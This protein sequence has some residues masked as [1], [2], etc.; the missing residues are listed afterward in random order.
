MTNA[1]RDSQALCPAHPE[2]C[3]YQLPHTPISRP[4]EY[5]HTPTLP[6]LPTGNPTQKPAPQLHRISGLEMGGREAALAPSVQK[7]PK[8][9]PQPAPDLWGPTLRG[10]QDL[11][12]WAG[13]GLRALGWPGSQSGIPGDTRFLP[14]RE[15]QTGGGPDTE[16]AGP[17]TVLPRPAPERTHA[18]R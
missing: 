11:L 2:L 7:D 4:T 9:C 3:L 12:S 17:P 16:W 1:R 10:S 13:R 14:A 6:R 5:A 8:L 18:W 15:A